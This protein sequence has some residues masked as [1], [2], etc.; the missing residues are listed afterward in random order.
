MS[1]NKNNGLSVFAKDLLKIREDYQSSKP[2][3]SSAQ[4]FI[5][6]LLQLLF[7]HF[8]E[9]EY[10]NSREIESKIYLLRRNLHT[11]LSSLN[12]KFKEDAVK[13][14]SGFFDKLP[15]LHNNL[16]KDAQAIYDGDP[17]AESLDEVILAYPG[18]FAIA[19]YRIAHELYELNV[20]LLPRVLSEYAHQIT[21]IDI[22]PGARI[23]A[24]FF[25]DHGTGIV[26]GET[27]FIGDNVKIYQGVTLGALSV[28]KELAKKKRHPTIEDNVIIYSNAVI[29]GGAT[30]IGNGSVIG[31]NVWL[32]R[33]VP[34][35][36]AVQH[37]S[38]ISF[39][40][41]TNNNELNFII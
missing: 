17:A 5:N 21:G 27:T 24:S 2:I 9:N 1:I 39:K 23:G 25:I 40:D 18:F 34:P 7:P 6:D 8:S 26:I 12:G 35:N 20:P 30:T 32:T 38:E 14:A 13:C 3:K 33:S 31:G 11:I 36:S 22:H 16:Y 19:V 41:E 37:R 4:A 10:Y 29:L 15:T 28:Q